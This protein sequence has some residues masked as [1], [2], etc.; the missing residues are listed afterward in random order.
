MAQ[1]LDILREH[2]AGDVTLKSGICY[3]IQ[4]PR[5]EDCLEQVG[6][7]PLPVLEQLAAREKAEEG[8]ELPKP[9]LTELKA[10]A[11]LNDA[12]VVLA[13]KAINGTAVEDGEIAARD[14]PAA[15]YDDLRDYAKRV[16]P[17]PGKE[18]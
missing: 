1:A 10:V 2:S 9:N 5:F 4:P 7:V 8:E 15:D 11:A 6:D 16:K 3:T 14:I 18:D 13:V 12:Y 17:L